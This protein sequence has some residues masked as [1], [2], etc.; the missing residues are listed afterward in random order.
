MKVSSGGIAMGIG[1][2][3]A[4]AGY[5]IHNLWSESIGFGAIVFGW[6]IAVVGFIGHLSSRGESK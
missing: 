5:L 3:V 2:L 4:V 6:V 1:V